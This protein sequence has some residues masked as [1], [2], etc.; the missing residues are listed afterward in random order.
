MKM[1]SLSESLA[2]VSSEVHSNKETLEDLKG[3]IS[4]LEAR[5]NEIEKSMSSLMTRVAGLAVAVST[6]I[7]GFIA[8]LAKE[9]HF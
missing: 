6:A 5:Q 7:G 1:V 4:K 9:L 8:W 2:V 3:K